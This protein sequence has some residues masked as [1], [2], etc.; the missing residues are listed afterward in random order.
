MNSTLKEAANAAT[1]ITDDVKGRASHVG[2]HARTSLLEY[3]TQALKLLGALRALEIGA[4][5]SVLARV[6]VGRRQSGSMLPVIWFTAGALVA[7]GAALA[8]AP[9]SGKDLRRRVARWI[10]SGGTEVEKD[11][12]GIETH[13]S[14]TAEAA[15]RDATS[16]V[17]HGSEAARKSLDGG[18][19]GVA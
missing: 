8:F 12:K 9:S 14:E 19:H 10:D 17:S 13:V 2:I 16:K 5:D 1:H 18:G 7:G 11:T 3:G 15:K 6:G 4:V